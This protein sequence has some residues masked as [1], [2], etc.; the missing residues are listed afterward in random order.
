[1]ARRT[2]HQIAHI[3]L[4]DPADLPRFAALGVTANLSPGWF[5]PND[6]EIAPAEAA[7]GPERARRMYPAASIAAHNGRLVMS[8]DWP[9]TAM[10]PLG[11]S[12]SP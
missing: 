6:P 1:M 3:E 7:L 2:A 4:A 11:T 9:A 10:N 8:S 12:R 5:D